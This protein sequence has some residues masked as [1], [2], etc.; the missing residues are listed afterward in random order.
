[1]LKSIVKIRKFGVP[2]AAL[3]C[4]V[5][6]FEPGP[7]MVNSLDKLGKAVS[8]VIVAGPPEV[9][10]GAKVIESGPAAELAAEI[11]SRR[12][13]PSPVPTA[14]HAPSVTSA[15]EFTSKVCAGELMVRPFSA[16]TVGR[17]TLQKEFFPPGTLVKSSKSGRTSKI[18]A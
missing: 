18:G 7:V 8:N 4:T 13:Q 12:V 11:A 10:A 14:V 5:K 16:L 9:K 15:V 3:R 1:V 6:R 17:N 2:P